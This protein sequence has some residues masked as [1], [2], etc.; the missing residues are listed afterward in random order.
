MED[1]SIVIQEEKPDLI[2]GENHA[3]FV[4]MSRAAKRQTNSK[5]GAVIFDAHIDS[6]DNEDEVKDALNQTRVRSAWAV[7]TA[8]AEG[9]IDYSLI[10]GPQLGPPKTVHEYKLDPNMPYF[11]RLKIVTQK[12]FESKVDEEI[13]N[14][15]IE[16]GKRG[17]KNIVISIDI[18]ILNKSKYHGF[19][20]ND[21]HNMVCMVARAYLYKEPLVIED[22]LE[23]IDHRGSSP[24]DVFYALELIYD[25]A[26]KNKITIVYQEITELNHALDANGETTN[27][28]TELAEFML[29]NRP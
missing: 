25:Q 12:D 2:L 28:A 13:N 11:E 3:T 5:I 7:G 9:T 17:I 1:A 14:F 23:S 27:A 29:K 16:L 6:F 19:R 24:E 26:K 18:D 20:Y 4:A 15:F 22:A 21:V 8:I 10:L